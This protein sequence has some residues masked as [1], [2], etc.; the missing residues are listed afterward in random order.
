MISTFELLEPLFSDVILISISC[1]SSSISL[2]AGSSASS[3][4]FTFSVSD[5]AKILGTEVFFLTFFFSGFSSTS[6]RTGIISSSSAGEAKGFVNTFLSTFPRNT[7]VFF[8][9]AKENENFGLSIFKLENLNSSSRMNTTERAI[10]ISQS[11][12]RPALPIRG[13]MNSVI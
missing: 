3:S 8:N 2:S 11:S 10:T 9:H 1:S 4:A 12:H 7:K 5:L 13:D 6:S